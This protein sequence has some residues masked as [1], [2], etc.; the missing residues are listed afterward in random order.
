ML[1]KG[2]FFFFFLFQ[3]PPPLLFHLVF[4]YCLLFVFISLLVT[5]LLGRVASQNSRASKWGYSSVMM[6]GPLVAGAPLVVEHSL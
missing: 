6:C 3:P 5:L 2:L 4:S 1:H